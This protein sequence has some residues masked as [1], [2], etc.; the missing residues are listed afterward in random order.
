M[1]PDLPVKR[2][3]K[4]AQLIRD[5]LLALRTT[6]YDR[7]HTQL[8]DIVGVL[9]QLTAF[10]RN[11]RMCGSRGWERS[12]NRM[13]HRVERLLPDQRYMI[14]RIGQTIESCRIEIP[15]LRDLVAEL[16][17][18]EQ[19]FGQI[20]WC[21]K[22]G[23]VSVVTEPIELEGVEL[24]EF[25]I[26]LEI[27]RLADLDRDVP[28][29]V[30]AL[31]PH[32]AA[33][34]ASVSHP[35]V[36]D[37]RLCTGDA[38]AAIHAALAAGRICDLFMLVRAVLTTYNPGSPYVRLEQWHGHACEDCGT[39][40]ADEDTYFCHECQNDFC[41]ECA[42]HCHRCEYTTCLGCLQMCSVCEEDVCSSCMTS[43]PECGR[44]LCVSCLEERQCPCLEE[45]DDDDDPD[46]VEVTARGDGPVPIGPEVVRQAEQI[47]I[48]PA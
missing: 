43:C 20:N 30:V 40:V 23:C 4:I 41:G 29:H 1:K 32:P 2:L 24:G 21:A 22:T 10:G 3:A 18:A 17:A 7:L 35:H 37:E 44:D 11:I 28:Y 26:M 12:A 19:E 5:R 8:R 9:D 48:T 42:S 45:M 36:S 34:N 6:R 38:S 46:P 33:G 25:E 27:N 47:G 14:E 15:S 16:Q 39:V 31:D 13:V